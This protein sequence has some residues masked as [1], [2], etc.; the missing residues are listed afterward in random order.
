MPSPFVVEPA[1]AA[2]S[3]GFGRGH[4][5]K[6]SSRD[7]GKEPWDRKRQPKKKTTLTP[8]RKPAAKTAAKKAGRRYPNL[9]DNMREAATSRHLMRPTAHARRR[10]RH[11]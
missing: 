10:E 3:S 5:A 1:R 8:K 7:T 9:V 11:V 4:V 2:A 6:S